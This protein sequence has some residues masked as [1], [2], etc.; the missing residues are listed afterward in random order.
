MRI[1]LQKFFVVI[2]LDH[3]RVDVAEPF[4]H[5]LGRVTE[6]GNEPKRARPGMKCVSDRIDRIVGNGK[7][8]HGDIADRKIRAGLKQPPVPMPGQ[9]AAANCF[10]SE[11]VTIDRNVKFP[12]KHFE[13]ANVIAMFVGEENAI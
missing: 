10:R 4:H 1:V 9:G 2:G 8:L 11:R 13:A 7:R 6:I 3:E 12:A 5:H